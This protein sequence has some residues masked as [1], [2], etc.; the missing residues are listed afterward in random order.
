MES[1][2]PGCKATASGWMNRALP[3]A[4][5]TSLAR[6]RRLPRAHAAA[7]HGGPQRRPS[8][9]ESIGGFQVR[10]AAAAH[11]FEQMYANANDPVLRAAGR[12]TFE[13][14]R[15]L[16]AIQRQPYTPAAGAEYPRGRF[17]DSLRQ[18]AQLIKAD[19]GMEMAFA[20]VGGWDHHV[21][22][23]GAARIRG[24]AG[25]PAARLRPGAGR[26]LDRHGR[27]HGRRGAW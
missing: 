14:V 19:V 15:M 20:D 18:I 22:E 13:A 8:R 17:G 27:P 12:E 25:Q 23:L 1:G 24:P 9:C 4:E 21:N 2:T 10:D 7:R 3:A 26:V 6:A 16:E 11:E 5:G